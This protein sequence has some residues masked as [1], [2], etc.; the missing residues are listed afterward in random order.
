MVQ[1]DYEMK[2]AQVIEHNRKSSLLTFEKQID[3]VNRMKAKNLVRL[4]IE[5]PDAILAWID[6]K[7]VQTKLVLIFCLIN[8]MTEVKILHKKH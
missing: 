4:G 8:G 2:Q 1:Q 5:A 6:V 7:L 3:H